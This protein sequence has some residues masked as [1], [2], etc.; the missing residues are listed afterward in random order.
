MVDKNSPY[1]YAPTTLPHPMGTEG[2][3]LGLARK[4]GLEVRLS[5]Y[6]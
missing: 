3:I 6:F 2:D 4:Q 5:L 1:D